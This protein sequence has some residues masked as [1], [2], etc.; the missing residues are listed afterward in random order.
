MTVALFAQVKRRQERR[1]GES[2]VEVEA[3]ER[4]METEAKGMSSQI[5]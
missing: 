2:K 3:S 1:K 5:I 4:D